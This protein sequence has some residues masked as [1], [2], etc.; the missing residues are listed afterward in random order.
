[1]KIDFTKLI[2]L[3]CALFAGGVAAQ[4]QNPEVV[5][6]SGHP[7][8]VE[9]IAFSANGEMLASADAGGI[10]KLWDLATYKEARTINMG[11]S[12]INGAP[13]AMAFSPDDKW[14][15]V[16]AQ[17][18]SAHVFEVASGRK[19]SQHDKS[20][21]YLNLSGAAIHIQKMLAAQLT[22]DEDIQVINLKDGKEKFVFSFPATN[23]LK[24]NHFQSVV[25]S[26]DGNLLAGAL[27]GGRVV[28]V[29]TATAK[30]FRIFKSGEAS[31]LSFSADGGTL[32]VYEKDEKAGIHVIKLRAITSEQ[33]KRTIDLK[34]GEATSLAF[35][36]NGKTLAAIVKTK[37]EKE[38]LDEYALRLWDLTTGQEIRAPATD[39]VSSFWQLTEV[40]FNP[41]GQTLAIAAGDVTEGRI[42]LRD[43]G[44]AREIAQLKRQSSDVNAIR[45][46][47][48]GQFVAEAT[49]LRFW[50]LTRGRQIINQTLAE[51]AL[52]ADGQRLAAYNTLLRTFEVAEVDS[53]KQICR[54]EEKNFNITSNALVFS[55]DDRFL[56]V[57]AHPTF[58]PRPEDRL[59]L[60]DVAT[61]KWLFSF[62]DNARIV[63][64]SRD[65]K[66][67]AYGVTIDEKNRKFALKIW[68]VDGRRE[69]Q[70]VPLQSS[71]TALEFNRTGD[72]LAVASYYVD[73]EFASHYFLDL[74]SVQDGKL[75]RAFGEQDMVEALAFSQD[76]TVLASG[77]SES[78]K[79]WNAADGNE[80]G[81]LTGHNAT[82]NSLSF[83][84]D[85]KTL[86]SG[87]DDGQVIFWDYNKREITSR[88]IVV[89]EAD[90]LFVTPD[91][92]YLASRRGAAASIAF[93]QGTRAFPF[94][95]FDI[96]FNR[97]DLVIKTLGT[98]EPERLKDYATAYQRR[99]KQYGLTEADVQG[100][101]KLPEVGIATRLIPTVTKQKNLSF[102]VKA[103]DANYALARLNV[104]VNDVPLYGSQGL[105]VGAQKA[106]NLTRDVTLELLP[107][108]NRVQ[109]S[110]TNEKGVESM[111]RTFGVIYE[112]T[113]APPE[114]YILAIG[115]AKYSD[116][117]FNLNY[118]AQDAANIV[119]LFEDRA[120]QQEKAL[121]IDPKGSHEDEQPKSFYKVHT[122]LLK[123]EQVTL[124]K[125]PAARSFLERAK[126]N[127]QLVVFI[128]GHGL[129]DKDN[130]YY[131][132][133]YDIDFDNPAARGLSY[134][135]LEKLL[136]NLPARRKLLLLDT[137]HAGEVEKGEVETLKIKEPISAGG[138]VIKSLDV[139]AKSGKIRLVTSTFK[140]SL[141]LVSELFADLRLGS[142][143]SV[144]SASGGLEYAYESP[145]W[146]GGVFTYALRLGLGE[147]QADVNPFD[148]KISASELRDFVR[149]KVSELTAG[150]Q[151]PTFRRESVEFDYRIY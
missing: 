139:A 94:E 143:V 148:G 93:R 54:L 57:H 115:V 137:C 41:D 3:L 25:F 130:N 50:D 86:A 83:A 64:F 144:V 138:G 104:Y 47:K 13:N 11:L 29:N 37:N 63:A 132:A 126:I 26:P 106:K 2:C 133:M 70:A 150:R 84:P 15:F 80:I 31:C 124:E 79:L 62:P 122:M 108:N 99:L 49:G 12:E 149:V 102:Q 42:Y 129:L 101:L 82:V 17:D 10:I 77:N 60:F 16:L 96:R 24:L 98:T 28:L 95:Q 55:P 38:D 92:Y 1:M 134:E 40:R 72:G 85:G 33:I 75:G 123:N 39:Y 112:G 30:P 136:D 151:R 51:H 65:G 89:G 103:D 20:G 66:R 105:N 61:G 100:E 117:S 27:T 9:K 18:R 118:P 110:V 116:S 67:L 125:I 52:S 6:Q 35:S 142:G 145:R 90:Y 71:V 78:V 88:L 97:P 128:S 5:V 69:L 53:G 73:R 44:T 19:V 21:K 58:N 76:G 22:D 74:Y 131:F 127:D 109:V 34:T 23:D 114:L 48:N 107:G 147:M 56:L 119:K 111:R 36:P 140:N 32:A 91:N 146:S 68:D 113:T 43:V 46:L 121:V 7:R 4:A 135:T 81:V 141:E 45:Y 8:I 14:L 87:G 120:T 59:M